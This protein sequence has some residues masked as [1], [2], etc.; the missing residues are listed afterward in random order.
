[1]YFAQNASALPT[2]KLKS[3]YP[4][5][6][7]LRIAL[8]VFRTECLSFTY[9]DTFPAMRYKDGKPYRGKVYLLTE[10]P[11]LVNEYGLPQIWNAQ[12]KYGPER[13]IEAQVWDDEPLQK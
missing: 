6:C 11:G 5:G 8:N 9:G 7:E 4:H 12:G 10:L 1:M 13:Y 2:E 3:W